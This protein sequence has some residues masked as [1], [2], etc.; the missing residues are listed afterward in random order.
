MQLTE[1]NIRG[2]KVIE[3]SPN[4]DQLGRFM[5][6][7]SAREFREQGIDFQPVETNLELSYRTGT[8]RGMHFEAAPASGINLVR[9][10]RGSIF[11]VVIDLRPGSQSYGQWHGSVL[12]AENGRMLYIPAQCAHGYQTLEDE[13]EVYYMSSQVY[14]PSF[15][16][17]VRYDDP[18]FEVRWPLTATE[19]SDQDRSWPLEQGQ[20]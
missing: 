17:G 7:W 6:A 4:T 13:T 10:T 1:T 20:G 18:A 11:D 12:T 9:C 8:V 14:V 16:R 2:I 5:S 3:P 15:M 19:L